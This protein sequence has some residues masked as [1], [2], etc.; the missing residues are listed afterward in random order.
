LFIAM[1]CY[2]GETLKERIARGPLPIDEAVGIA[3]QLCNAL[4]Q[5]HD[6]GIVHRDVKPANILI[7]PNGTVKVVDFGLAK[8]RGVSKITMDASTVGTIGFMAPEQLKGEAVDHRADIWSLGIVL[9]HMLA[10]Q[11]PWKGDYD[12]A[13]AYEVVNE[14]HRPLKEIKPDVPEQ[15]QEIVEKA[16][17]KNPDD[18]YPNIDALSEDLSS[19]AASLGIEISAPKARPDK[20]AT[21]SRRRL[22]VVSAI[23]LVLVV[24]AAAFLR[25]RFAGD[26]RQP[27]YVVPASPTPRVSHV[28]LKQVTFSTGLE[29]YPSL[30]PDGSRV[31]FCAEVD[32]FKQIF[33][34]DLQSQ[35]EMQVTDTDSDNI[36]PEWSPDGETVLFVRSRAA[37]GK[38]EP[39]DVFGT[40]TEG[41]I[42][43]HELASTEEQK[44]VDNA[45]NP[46][47][48]PD[49]T[50]I[51]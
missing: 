21:T 42:W 30:S 17:A 3:T 33:I 37:G 11:S 13:V 48:S 38:L 40:H 35:E 5:A 45:F 4:K 44:I 14:P 50:R 34:K 43:L 10:G 31:A 36:Q 19:A 15:L 20:P 28:E 2:E 26:A 27:A 23:A 47:Y 6:V 9:Y 39:G 7:D 12:Q 46:S 41:D 8:L 25:H 16:L 29:E 1:A 49:G 18:R 51:A 24:I 22:Y 32:R